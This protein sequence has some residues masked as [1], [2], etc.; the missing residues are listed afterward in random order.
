MVEPSLSTKNVDIVLEP[1]ATLRMRYDGACERA[2][3]GIKLD[4]V[5]VPGG[6]IVLRGATADHVVPAGRSSLEVY[7]WGQ[8]LQPDQAIDLTPGEVREFVI[9]DPP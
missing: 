5:R 7:L 6:G 4:G 2:S 9:K 1:A 3:V 8:G